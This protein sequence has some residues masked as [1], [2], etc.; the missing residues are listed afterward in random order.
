M[1]YSSKMVPGLS[2]MLD[3]TFREATTLREAASDELQLAMA[4][5]AFCKSLT[6]VS[7]GD[8]RHRISG[9]CEAS[10][11]WPVPV[12][13]NEGDN[14]GNNALEETPIDRIGDNSIAVQIEGRGTN[15]R[16]ITMIFINGWLTRL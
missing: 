5:G 10:V 2:E 14:T 4:I 12:S 9:S 16:C 7:A 11:S 15:I 13:P 3:G 1:D 8:A 6:W